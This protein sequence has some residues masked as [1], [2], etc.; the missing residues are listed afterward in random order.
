MAWLQW[1]SFNVM[2]VDSYMVEK[3]V[4]IYFFANF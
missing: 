1:K 4:N 3:M 2:D